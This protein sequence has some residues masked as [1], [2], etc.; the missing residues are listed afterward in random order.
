MADAPIYQIS[1]M[2]QFTQSLT[3]QKVLIGV[4]DSNNFLLSDS[5]QAQLE[6]YS[7]STTPPLLNFSVSGKQMFFNVS[8]GS[9]Y[10][11]MQGVVWSTFTPGAQESELALDLQFSAGLMFG[12]YKVLN[13]RASGGLVAGRNT[14]KVG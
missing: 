6:A 1:F 3:D 11:G 13:T 12:T 10:G 14:I 7:G 9:T 4:V 8:Q 5:Q 2:F